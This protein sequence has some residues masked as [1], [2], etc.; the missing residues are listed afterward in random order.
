MYLFSEYRLKQLTIY[1][2]MSI[3]SVRSYVL[4]GVEIHFQSNLQIFCC[5]L[6]LSQIFTHRHKYKQK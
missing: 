4:G 6:V 3:L 2:Q 1:V 5:I